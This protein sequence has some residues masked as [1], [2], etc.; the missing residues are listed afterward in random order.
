M[1]ATWIFILVGLFILAM[2]Y[3]EATAPIMDALLLCQE[4][5]APEI[6]I[7]LIMRAYHVAFI[8]LPAGIILYGILR[9]IR[10]EPDTYKL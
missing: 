8:I 2:I 7:S 4:H 9:T 1:L 5:G 6:Y 3:W 10:K